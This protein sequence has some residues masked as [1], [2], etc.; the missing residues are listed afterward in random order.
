MDINSSGFSLVEGWGIPNTLK[1]T[2]NLRDPLTITQEKDIF[3][4]FKFSNWHFYSHCRKDMVQI[5]AVLAIENVLVT[6]VCYAYNPMPKYS[7]YFLLPSA[8]MV[9]LK[10]IVRYKEFHLYI[11]S[12]QALRGSQL[13]LILVFH[14][15]SDI[16]YDLCSTK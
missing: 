16:S 1:L 6:T 15:F 5:W 3:R 4:F 14:V 7:W 13:V 10:H 9:C 8:Q 11:L 12:S 2:K